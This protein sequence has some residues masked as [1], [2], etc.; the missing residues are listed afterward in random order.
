[1]YCVKLSWVVYYDEKQLNAISFN[2]KSIIH[3]K[4]LNNEVLQQS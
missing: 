2:T 3:G 1:M 4:H